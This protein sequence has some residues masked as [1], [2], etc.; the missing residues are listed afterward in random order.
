VKRERGFKERVEKVWIL[1]FTREQKV[2][3]RA[4][5]MIESEINSSMNR[6]I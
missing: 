3:R 5:A 1:R 4:Y 6:E 2:Q